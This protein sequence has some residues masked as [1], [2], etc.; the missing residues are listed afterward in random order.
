MIDKLKNFW[1]A[2]IMGHSYE[3]LDDKV[4][5]AN[6]EDTYRYDKNWCTL[7]AVAETVKR[8]V[9]YRW[10]SAADV[11]GVKDIQEALKL[12]E[13]EKLHTA[14]AEFAIRKYKND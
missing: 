8:Y 9:E 6:Y 5:N 3:S 4:F 13:F 12:L 10:T 14:L 2:K 1:I 11:S 7:I